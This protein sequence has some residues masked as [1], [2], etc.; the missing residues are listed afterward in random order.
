[1]AVMKACIKS[2]AAAEVRQDR[3]SGPARGRV[4]HQSLQAPP[5]RDQGAGSALLAALNQHCR[6]SGFDTPI[7]RPA[8]RS[9]SLWKR[10][11]FRPPDEL[12]ERPLDV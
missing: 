5:P 2:E 1:M 4:R 11:G 7:V 10:S 6:S 9:G 8:E 3:L 12:L